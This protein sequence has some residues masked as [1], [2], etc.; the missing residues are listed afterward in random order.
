MPP[1]AKLP[2]GPATAAAAVEQHKKFMAIWTLLPA[3][4]ADAPEPLDVGIGHLD[5][6]LVAV[7]SHF[8]TSRLMAKERVNLEALEEHCGTKYVQAL[9]VPEP[10]FESLR[11]VFGVVPFVLLPPL[12]GG[13]AVVL[14]ADW[15]GALKGLPPNE[16]ANMLCAAAGT[17]FKVRGDVFVGRVRAAAVVTGE[18]GLAQQ[19]LALGVDLK[20]TSLMDRE[21]LEA[22]Q[23]ANAAGV[24]QAEAQTIGRMLSAFAAA[25]VAQV[26]SGPQPEAAAQ[27]AAAATAAAPAVADDPSI[28]KVEFHDASVEG[29]TAGMCTAS[30][31][32]PAGTTKSHVHCEV[33]AASTR[34]LLR[35]DTLA[36]GAQVRAAHCAACC[37]RMPPPH[38]ASACMHA[39]HTNSASLCCLA[40]SSVAAAVS[41]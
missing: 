24:G 32:V 17:P 27:Q 36:E 30:V 29:E 6:T 4:K 12:D 33:S 2:P 13:E 8:S 16:R 26:Q 39:C 35:V 22:A 37:L 10:L 14:L 11:T 9:A 25:A 1:T 31:R 38:S 34:L 18:Q 19:G 23:V 21:W 41:S 40:L 28:G 15:H 3:D 20:P 5:A 7:A